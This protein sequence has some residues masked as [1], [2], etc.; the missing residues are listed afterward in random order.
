MFRWL[1]PERRFVIVTT[2]RTGS[3]LLVS[4]LDS[5]PAIRCDGEIFFT[6]RVAPTGFLLRHAAN[7]R[8][9]GAGAYGF[10]LLAHHAGL[11][12]I[13]DAGRFLRALHERGFLLIVL[14]RRDLLQQ[15]ISRVRLAST[16]QHYRRADSAVFSPLRVD[17][18]AII[19]AMFL[20]E[21]AVSSVREALADIPQL[22]LVYEDDLADAEAQQSTAD[23]ICAYLDL[24]PAPV[25]SDLVR[26]APRS[27]R[28]QVENFA[29]LAE[30]LSGTRYGKYLNDDQALV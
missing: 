13:E 9:K 30:L 3:E 2:G 4:L 27:T 29:E 19:A 28:E 16:Q 22:N 12:D 24:T 1:A 18:M 25:E 17:P 21:D 6:R 20:I 5:H 14:E 10:K 26:Y 23:R 7:A 11:Q 8:F 15:A